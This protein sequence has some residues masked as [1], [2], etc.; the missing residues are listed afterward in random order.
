MK[1]NFYDYL[2]KYYNPDALDPISRL[3]NRSHDDQSFPKHSEDFE[4]ISSYL[5][6]NPIYGKLLTVFDDLWHNYQAEQ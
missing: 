4:E 2:Q 6:Q 1:Q 3:A 5:E